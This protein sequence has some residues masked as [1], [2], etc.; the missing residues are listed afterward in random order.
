[1]TSVFAIPYY[2]VVLG[3]LSGASCGVHLIASILL[4]VASTMSE[5]PA[6]A[7]VNNAD[8]SSAR[9]LAFVPKD[10]VNVVIG[11]QNANIYPKLNQCGMSRS[12]LMPSM[13]HLWI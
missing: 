13:S 12:V 2:S 4:I 8:A 9:G 10:T 11:K 7:S 5:A 3:L 1:M 6:S